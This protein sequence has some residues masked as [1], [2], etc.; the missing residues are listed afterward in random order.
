MKRL[1]FASCLSLSL[2]G[3]QGKVTSALPGGCDTKAQLKLT[4]PLGAVRVY[5]SQRL[6][7]DGSRGRIRF[8]VEPSESG[9][10]VEGDLYHAGGRA[11][12]DIVWVDD[13]DCGARA[14]LSI[15]VLENLRV[16]PVAATVKPQ[17]TFRLEVSGLLGTPTF[18]WMQNG[19]G[20]TLTEQGQYTAGAKQGV[21][22]F[23]VADPAS[24]EQV[25]VRYQVSASAR[26]RLSPE[27]LAVLPGGAGLLSARDGTDSIEYRSLRGP[28]RIE[29]NQVLLPE[30]AT[31][32]TWVEARDLFTGLLAEGVVHP[33]REFRRESVP[34]GRIGMTS[35]MA[36]ADFDAD[37]W[38]DLAVGLPDSDLARTLG[39]AVFIYRGGPGGLPPA[40]TWTLPGSSDTAQFGAALATG[41]FNGDGRTDLAVAAPG[42]D[43]VRADS[44]A[45]FLY[46][47]DAGG[48]TALRA[49]L[50][51]L[52]TGRFGSSVVAADVNADGLADLLVGSINA[53]V[54][55]VRPVRGTV[56]VFIQKSGMGLSDIASFR[57][58]GPR[59]PGDD[60]VPTVSQRA[61]KALAAADFNSDGRVDLV[62]LGN[63]ATSAV[64]AAAAVYLSRGGTKPYLDSPDA[65]ILPSNSADTL[66]GT[67]RMGPA[68]VPGGKTMLLLA[69]DFADGP[70]ARTNAGAALLFDLSGL[71]A[72]TSAPATAPQLKLEDAFARFYGPSTGITAGRSYTFFDIDGDGAKELL[73]GAPH[74]SPSGKRY[75][76][77]LLAYRLTGLAKGTVTSVPLAILSETTLAQG[78]G[79]GVTP[80]RTADGLALAAVAGRATTERGQF[81]GRLD[82]YLPRGDFA[83]WPKTSSAFP[84]QPAI[85]AFG[86]S[87]ALAR[88]AG[89][90]PAAAIGSPGY[91]GPG[92]FNDGDDVTAGRAYRY[93]ARNAQ[94]GQVTAEGAYRPMVRGGRTLAGSVAFTD[95]N[96]DARPD[97]VINA[98]LLQPPLPGSADAKVYA[99]E[100]AECLPAALQTTGGLMVQLG[101]PDGS[102]APAFHLWS[103]ATTTGCTP[104]SAAC[105][106]IRLGT[107]VAGGFDFNGDGKQDVAAARNT[108]AKADGTK[109]NGLEIFLGR[110]PDNA[111]LT[112]L[113]MGCNPVLREE[114]ADAPLWV[115][116]IGDV[117]GDGCD[118]V[119]VRLG[120]TTGA[121]KVGIAFGFA[122]AGGKCKRTSPRVMWIGDRDAGLLG[123][124]LGQAIS[125]AGNF[126]GNGRRMLAISVSS[127]PAAGGTFQPAV[128]MYDYATLAAHS[129][130]TAILPAIGSPLSPKVLEPPARAVGFGRALAGNVDMD[131][132]GTPDLLVAS[133]NAS[134]ASDG[135]GAV[136]LFRGGPGEGPREPWLVAHGAETERGSFGSSVA[137]LGRVTGGD[138]YLVIGSPL[139]YRTGTHNGSAYVLP[140]NF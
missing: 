94:Q 120:A 77:Q 47:F 78:L 123:M 68:P 5:T 112:S 88:V 97:L 2:L 40:P 135:G 41:D 87:V 131:G 24:G 19:S 89:G 36:A 98:P 96:G 59:F 20:G 22:L 116:G 70:S 100:R 39:G 49:P 73:L 46:R 110:A 18:Q 55:A 15:E 42:S 12:K 44:G 138:A 115:S 119:A 83:S 129:E 128:L 3:C 1:F 53:D 114:Y 8:S 92:I 107:A 16:A 43:L 80:W 104:G 106:R 130:A 67:W 17:T 35:P 117:D 28:G 26:F 65:F 132:D 81:T 86:T 61:G 126:Y 134:W 25:L 57:M 139:S 37:G 11:G 69:A 58:A 99:T 101:Q 72:G 14:S 7:V 27:R 23:T 108:G 51:G 109:P 102:F 127:F 84:A 71:Q 82:V 133:P 56:D 95:F 91:S 103:N 31:E 33:L 90:I 76:G 4:A 66:E 79:A 38:E 136:F 54:G 85:E 125:P 118:E 30:W 34:H 10:G 13:V 9:G 122:P 32:E 52:G 74:A 63:V 48:P 29:G 121:A 137:T 124:G 45:V 105:A 75:A 50:S 21:D 113:T 64:P 60:A 111:Q 140:L 6:R 62:V 93:D